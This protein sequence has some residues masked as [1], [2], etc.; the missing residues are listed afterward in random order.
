MKLRTTIPIISL[1]L[2]A[3]MT[4]WTEERPGRSSLKQA[5]HYFYQAREGHFEVVPKLVALLE[6]ATAAEPKDAELWRRLA[7]AYFVEV[8][9]A[10]NAGREV[11]EQAASAERASKAFERALEIDPN[12]GQALTGHGMAIMILSGMRQKWELAG[13]GVEEMNRGVALNPSDI[14]SRLLR[15]FTLINLPPQLRDTKI[16]IED[17]DMLIDVAEGTRAGDTLHIL[18]GDVYAEGG[19]KDLARTQYQATG[20]TG[21]E[22]A[23]ARL[24]A[25]E[26]GAIPA[27][28]I[29]RMR[30]NIGRNCMMCH[31]K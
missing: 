9:A 10:A 31:A 8:T 6:Q 19:N 14:G 7:A 1:I 17:L 28:E 30:S 25:L 3:G 12:D 26:S 2:L 5:T 4:A 11:A 29:Q 15:G 13:K 18:L 21:Q 16:V 22:Q 24:A 27:A 20:K 23:R